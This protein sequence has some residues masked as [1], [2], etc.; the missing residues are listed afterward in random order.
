MAQETTQYSV[1]SYMGKESKREVDICIVVV[2]E[3]QVMSD[4]DQME[5]SVTGSSV[6]HYLLEFAQVHVH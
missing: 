5:C 2:V 3:L 4:C 1:M 6:L